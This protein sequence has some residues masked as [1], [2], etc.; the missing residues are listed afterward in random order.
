MPLVVRTPPLCALLFIIVLAAAEGSAMLLAAAPD[1][2]FLWF[3]NLAVF[4]ALRPGLLALGD[5]IGGGGPLLAVAAGGAALAVTACLWRAQLLGAIL[6][7]LGF[8]VCAGLVT[9]WRHDY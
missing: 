8:F 5:A 1:S 6:S 4:P 2:G 7:N 9:C 3:L